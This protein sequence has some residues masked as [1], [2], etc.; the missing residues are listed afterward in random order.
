LTDTAATRFFLPKFLSLALAD[1]YAGLS[2]VHGNRILDYW[3]SSAQDILSCHGSEDVD[4]DRLGFN[5][6]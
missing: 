2:A 6:M 1:F 3:S 4:I 5:A